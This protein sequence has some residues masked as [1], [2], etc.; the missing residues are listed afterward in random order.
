VKRVHVLVEGQ[1][2]ETF[3]RRLLSPH[4]GALGV[5]LTPIII[6]TKRL[7]SGRKLKGGIG[8]YRQIRKDLERLL[9]DSSAAAVTTMIDYYGLPADVPGRSSLPRGG[10]VWE[11]A[12]HLEDSMR[13]D[14]GDARLLPY[15][16]VHEFEA[17]LLADPDLIERVLSTQGLGRSLAAVT[18]AAGS[19]EEVDDGPTSHPAARIMRLAPA[20]QKTVHGPVITG[21]IGLGV[22]RERC[23]HFGD[24]LCRLEALAR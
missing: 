2:E 10:T 22:L 17:L 11:R 7:K 20:Y 16:S 19:P 8:A 23:P 14:L 15:L 4:L 3:T 18:S 6:T 21:R 13:A 12:R 9:G 24:W 1:T 5:H